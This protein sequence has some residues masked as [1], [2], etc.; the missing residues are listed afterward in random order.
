MDA[1]SRTIRLLLFSPIVCDWHV[2][3]RV[4]SHDDSLIDELW[5]WVQAKG[6]VWWRPSNQI[7]SFSL[8][9]WWPYRDEWMVVEAWDCG[10][11]RLKVKTRWI[12]L[13]STKPVVAL[14][15]SHVEAKSIRSFRCMIADLS[16]PT[17]GSDFPSRMYVHTLVLFTF[18]EL[19]FS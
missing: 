8:R 6:Q 11:C 4:A 17:P 14:L 13:Q 7:S 18:G 15:L 2:G 9:V 12:L 19:F 5:L 3:C 10:E 16:R 1:L